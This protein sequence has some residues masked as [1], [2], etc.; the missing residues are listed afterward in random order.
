MAASTTTTPAAG[1]RVSLPDDLLRDTFGRMAARYTAWPREFDAVMADP[2]RS[3]L[4]RL[5]AIRRLAAARRPKPAP[6]GTPLRRSA[7][8]P[9]LAA[10][11]AVFDHKRA[12][13]GDRDD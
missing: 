12:A 2:I 8:P 5:T 10:L 1:T 11:P 9:R 7:S 4:V 13:A 3:R 6:C